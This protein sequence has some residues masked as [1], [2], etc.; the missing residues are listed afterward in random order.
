M[1]GEPL[2]AVRNLHVDFPS[3]TGVTQAV[4]GVSFAIGREKLGIVGESGSGKSVTGRAL[5]RL[6]PGSARVRADALRFGTTDILHASEAEMRAL[7]GGR[8]GLILQD[9]KYSLNPVMTAGAQIAEALRAHTKLGRREA[10]EAALNLLESVKIRDPRRVHDAYP[11]ELSGGMGQRVMIAMMLAPN[12]E[13]L[14]ADEPTS[15]LDAS[16]QAEILSLIEEQVDSRGMALMLISHDLPLV[17]RFCDRV[18]VMYAGQVMEELPAADLHRATHG[19]TRG[20]L[21]CLPSLEERRERLPTLR[22]D[23]SWLAP[24]A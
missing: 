19:Y 23:P 14:I 4:R 10:R 8:I 24:R 12:P 21:E 20:L 7:R 1:P 11:H 22:R 16:V 5:M 9:P 17:S 6:L 2:V 15:A 3:A 13:L 18:A